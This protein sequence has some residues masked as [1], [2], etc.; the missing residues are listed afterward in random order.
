MTFSEKRASKRIRNMLVVA[1]SHATLKGIDPKKMVVGTANSVPLPLFF[2]FSRGILMCDLFLF[3]Q[4][5]P[6]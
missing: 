6:G 5:K 2:S 4:L 3:A 1:R